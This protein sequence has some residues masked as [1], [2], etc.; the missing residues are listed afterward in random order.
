M[1]PEVDPFFLPET[2]IINAFVLQDADADGIILGHA[3]RNST[4]IDD[5]PPCEIRFGNHGRT[6]KGGPPETCGEIT[7]EINSVEPFGSNPFVHEL[8]PQIDQEVVLFPPVTEIPILEI[9]IRISVGSS[10]SE[11]NAPPA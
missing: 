9:A 5:I 1:D 11:V 10:V 3:V 8:T 7:S 6:G 4:A 2:A